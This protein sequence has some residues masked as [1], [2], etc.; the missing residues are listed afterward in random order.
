MTVAAVLF[1][2]G[3]RYGGRLVCHHGGVGRETE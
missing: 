1:A 2:V 3:G